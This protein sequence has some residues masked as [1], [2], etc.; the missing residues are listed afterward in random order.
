VPLE[1][2]AL[3]EPDKMLEGFCTEPGQEEQIALNSNGLMLFLRP[4]D[5]EWLAAADGCVTL[6]VGRETYRASE[7]VAAVEA[8]LPRGQFLHI[9]P[10]TLVNV[11]EIRGVQPLGHGRCAV[12]LRSGTR[13]IFLRSYPVSEDPR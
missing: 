5:I 4:V 7:T 12:L 6:H 3:P 1:W 11:R 2:V 9:A 10:T 8:K 13:L